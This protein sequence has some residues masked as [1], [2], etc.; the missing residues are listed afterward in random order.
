MVLWVQ[1]VRLD[2]KVSKESKVSKAKWATLA[3][4]E[5]KETRVLSE[6]QVRSDRLALTAQLVQ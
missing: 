3:R 1:R 6:P 5:R 2:R 4:L